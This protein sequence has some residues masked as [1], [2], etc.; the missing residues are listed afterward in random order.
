LVAASISSLSFLVS[1]WTVH[2]LQ[3]E[4]AARRR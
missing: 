3:R 4:V 1:M 2:S